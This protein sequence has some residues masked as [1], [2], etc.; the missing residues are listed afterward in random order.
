MNTIASKT[1][2]PTPARRTAFNAFQQK[3]IGLR[4]AGEFQEGAD[5]RIQIRHAFTNEDLSPPR[6][7]R[8]AK[9]R[10]TAPTHLPTTCSSTV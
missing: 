5:R 2:E 8:R 1:Y 10:E 9:R 7:Q 6:F 3:R 4:P